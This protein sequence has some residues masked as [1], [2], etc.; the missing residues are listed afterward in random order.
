MKPRT[1]IST[2]TSRVIL[3]TVI[4]VSSALMPG[5]TPVRVLTY[6]VSTEEARVPPGPYA[7][8]AN[9][10]SV[11]FDVMHL[12]YSHFV[13]RFD[14]AQGLL[15]WK[16]EG[17]ATSAV[18]VS[19]DAW[20]VDTK[21]PMLDKLVKG[22][23]MFDAEKYP[24]IRFVSTRFVRTAQATGKLEGELTIRDVTRPVSLN[25]TFNG[26]GVN[27][28]TRDDTL[29]FSA[30]GTFSRAQFGLATWYPAVGDDVHVRIE[31]EFEKKA[32]SRTE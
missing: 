2:S 29:G 11:T 15:D 26:Y 20:S 4:A 6:G 31:A 32:S 13:M 27:P 25:V 22:S 10:W 16:P 5:C 12:R 21:V 9:H 1:F 30:E 14:R 24:T 3:V 18:E 7:L 28:L 23:D 17:L 8:D 19:I